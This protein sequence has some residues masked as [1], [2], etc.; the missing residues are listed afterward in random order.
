[1]GLKNYLLVSLGAIDGIKE[2]LLEIS[3][4]HPKYINAKNVFMSTFK[5]GLNCNEIKTYLNSIEG[6]T[7]FISEINKKTLSV[8][9]GS[10]K[11]D[12]HLFGDYI[13]YI[14]TVDISE[15]YDDLNGN[16][17]SA[18]TTETPIFKSVNTKGSNLDI[19]FMT[20]SEIEESIDLLLDKGFFNLTEYDKNLLVKL[21]SIK[22]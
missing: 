2:D 16:P 12:E 3:E 4:G 19:R 5:S 10:K 1:M 22:K 15:S 11:F 21:N 6:R 9:L 13:D 18:T 17:F 8:S 20:D 7:F 14:N